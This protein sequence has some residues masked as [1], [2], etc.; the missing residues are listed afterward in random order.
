M[1]SRLLFL[2][3]TFPPPPPPHPTRTPGPNTWGSPGIPERRRKERKRNCEERDIGR[4]DAGKG[5]R[6]QRKENSTASCL[7]C[8]WKKAECHILGS[9]FSCACWSLIM[10]SRFFR[11]CFF[12]L[13][14]KLK[15]RNSKGTWWCAT[16][17]PRKIK[18]VYKPWQSTGSHIPSFWGLSWSRLALFAFLTSVAVV[19]CV[20]SYLLA[21]VFSFLFVCTRLL[22]LLDLTWRQ[23][24]QE[25]GD[26]AMPHY[27]RSSWCHV[28][29]CTVPFHAKSYPRQISMYELPRQNTT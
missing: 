27:T 21:C 19:A 23:N 16:E 24:G 12:L 1:K 13:E 15:E 5:K 18:I 25:Y 7:R 22:V 6:L 2:A 26:G 4:G 14:K 9:W 29:S 20:C 3:L 17:S 10:P 28:A 11:V 8:A